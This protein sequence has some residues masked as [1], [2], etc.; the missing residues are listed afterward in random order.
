[1]YS[2]SYVH[3]CS[4]YFGYMFPDLLNDNNNFLDF[5]QINIDLLTK[6]GNL[7]GDKRDNASTDSTIPAGYTYLGQFIDHDITLD[8]FSNI[9]QLQDP[10]LLKNFR[11]P[12]LD[13]DSVYGRGPAIDPFLYDHRSGNEFKLLLGTNTPTGPGGPDGFNPTDFD[14]PR[15]TDN[16]AIIGDPR[17][18]ENL[19]VSQLHHSILKFHNA[20]VDKLNNEGFAGDI[21]EEAR[22]LVTH[23]Y[24][25]I[26]LHDF[27]KTLAGN[28]VVDDVLN[29]G[30]I[31]FTGKFI[32]PVEFSVASYRF[33]HSMIRN[34]YSVNNNFQNASLQEVFL[35][36]RGAQ[37]PVFSNWAVDFN[38]F[39]PNPNSS[40]STNFA[41]KID[42]NLAK[43]L[44]D[45]FD[46]SGIMK[47]LAIRNLLRGLALKV[48]TG[49]A[50]AQAM[51]VTPLSPN[52]LI[53]HTQFDELTILKSENSL[54]LQK[55]PLWYYILKEAEVTES[56]N[57]LGEVGGRIVIETFIR[58]LQENPKSILNNSFTP[59]IPQSDGSVGLDFKMA[60]LLDFAGVLR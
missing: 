13:L 53:T 44:E 41:K 27:L 23:H 14:L 25:W 55:T 42:T 58:M 19:M 2:Q 7:L 11:S 15:T 57:Q 47:I 49:Q 56:G 39:F 46:A 17:N 38:R 28:T 48:P 26:V 59:S 29:N 37:L 50:V 45:L 20:V 9:D 4:D 18:N 21:F 5:N 6:L 43:G 30:L 36:V 24:Q 54:L 16:T 51:G 33:A 32:M 3:N 12:F 60:D 40:K 1:M 10:R 8:P 22:S 31:L 52:Q 35:F 34:N